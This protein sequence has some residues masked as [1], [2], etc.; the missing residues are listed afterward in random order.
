MT[1]P[2]SR[3]GTSGRGVALLPTFFA[4]ASLLDRKGQVRRSRAP[5]SRSL[6]RTLHSHSHQGTAFPLV[7][8]AYVQI[9][10]FVP[11]LRLSSFFSSYQIDPRG[12]FLLNIVID[13]TWSNIVRFCDLSLF[14]SA[15]SVSEDQ[16]TNDHRP[17]RA[18]LCISRDAAGPPTS[19]G[20]PP[21]HQVETSSPADP[22]IANR[23]APG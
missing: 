12:R 6:V 1:G 9:T 15:Q 22:R 18:V 3:H 13:L 2:T 16:I 14:A 11:R 10:D 7:P 19:S 21:S 20:S 8:Q 5:D 17:R 4:N 23:D